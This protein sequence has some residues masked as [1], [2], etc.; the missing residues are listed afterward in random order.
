M[1]RTRSRW[2]TASGAA[3]AVLIAIAAGQPAASASPEL[4]DRI[5]EWGGT[6]AN[7]DTR[8]EIRIDAAT[9]KEANGTF[10]GT[11]KSDGS[12]FFFDFDKV[13]SKVKADSVKLKRRKHTHWVTATANGV[14]LGYRRKNQRR[15][16]MTLD[17][18]TMQCIARITPATA[19]LGGND[20][21]A[22]TA[23]MTGTWSAY[24][25]RGKATEVRIVSHSEE[26]ASGTVCFVRKDDSVAYFDFTPGGR[27]EASIDGDRMTIERIPFKTKMTHVME[28]SAEGGVTYTEKVGNKPPRLTL[29][30][31]R[32]SVEDG[33]IR[34]IRPAQT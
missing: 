13:K 3:A 34:R 23:G 22:D 28:M 17:Q 32:G 10:C 31:K 29:E 5:G 30:L 11:R 2:N 9:A 15:Y 26:G 1:T 21:A 16:R 6:W 4:A 8:N 12:V 7:A 24:D 25:D 20:E 19:P 27:I 18:G 14:E 33:C